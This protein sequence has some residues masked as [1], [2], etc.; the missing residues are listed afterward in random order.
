MFLEPKSDLHVEYESHF[1]LPGHEFSM[2]STLCLNGDICELAKPKKLMAFLRD[3]ASKYKYVVYIMGNHEFYHGHMYKQL[4][5][6]REIIKELPNV[7]VLHNE[8]V[9]IEGINFI[10]STLWTDFDKGNPIMK[11]DC[12]AMMRDYRQIRYGGYQRVTPD[13]IHREHMVARKFIVDTLKTV[14]RSKTVVMTHHAPCSLSVAPQWKGDRLGGGYWSDLS[15][16]I[17]DFGP[18]YWFHG[19]MHESVDYELGD[20]R[21]INN[22]RGVELTPGNPQNV[23]WDINKA[24]EI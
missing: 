12:K 18:K 6:F 22:P 13:F 24:V 15:E 4:E 3:A 8:M 5:K 11:I 2:E 10:G 20:T 23:R 16:E 14:D 1:R 21:I 7:Y 17:L 9:T 19:H